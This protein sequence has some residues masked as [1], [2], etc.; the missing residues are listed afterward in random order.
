M[1]QAKLYLGTLQETKLMDGFYTSG[2][3]GYSAVAMDKPS[4]YRGRVAVFYQDSLPFSVKTIKQSSPNVVI[5][6][7]MISDRRWYIIRC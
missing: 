1:A 6:Q 5:F 3:A 7:I 2:M 4:Q